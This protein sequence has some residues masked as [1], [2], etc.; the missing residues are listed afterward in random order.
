MYSLDDFGQMIGDKTRVEAYIAAISR[1]VRPGDVVVDIGCGVGVFALLACRAGARKVYAIEGSDVVQWGKQIAAANGFGERI[2]FLQKDSRQVELAERAN[3]IVS[4]IRGSLPLFGEAIESIEDARKRMLAPGGIQIPQLDVL[5]AAIVDSGK[6]YEEITS[7][8]RKILAGVDLSCVLPPTLNSTYYTEISKDSLLTEAKEWCRL[9]Y[10][11]SPSK[12][13]AA[14]IPFTTI[15]PGT[16]NGIALWFE[17]QLFEDIHFGT[18]PS[19]G[20]TI[21]GR[22]FLPWLEPVTFEAGEEI[23]VELH[24]DLVGGAYIW[25]W[26]TKFPNRVEQTRNSFRQS[27]FESAKY[28]HEA[29]RRRAS[30][31]VPSLTELGEAQRWMLQTVDGKISLEEIAR[32]AATQFPKVFR[33]V[34]DALRVAVELSEKFSN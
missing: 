16:G 9:E 25:R 31:Y 23:E 26:E 30:G 5:Y 2:E 7:P 10:A 1:A 28:S 29:L 4:D 14:K 13:V 34:D 21:Y 15:K 27:T 12:R 3:V 17:T 19:A 24:A 11:A 8:W 32:S 22:M 18:G 6:T 20:E 33:N